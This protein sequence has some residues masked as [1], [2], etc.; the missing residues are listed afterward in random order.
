M[1]GV[2]G[3]IH[4]YMCVRCM[5]GMSVYMCVCVDRCRHVWDSEQVHQAGVGPCGQIQAGVR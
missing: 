2:V 5:Y 4:V 1:A 3:M